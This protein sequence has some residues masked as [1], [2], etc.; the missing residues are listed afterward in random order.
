MLYKRGG[1]VKK[2]VKFREKCV[3]YTFELFCY[4]LVFH[5]TENTSHTRI[6]K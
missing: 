2:H 6:I 3:R 4:K 1:G 5:K